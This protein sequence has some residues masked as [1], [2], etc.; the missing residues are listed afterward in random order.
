MDQMCKSHFD[1]T[2]ELRSVA[3]AAIVTDN[4]PMVIAAGSA[5]LVVLI[6]M[7]FGPKTLQRFRKK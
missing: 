5:V 2:T 7:C 3:T 4:L 1:S 6:L